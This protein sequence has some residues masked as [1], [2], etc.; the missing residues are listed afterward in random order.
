[1]RLSDGRRGMSE[2]AFLNWIKDYVAARAESSVTLRTR[3]GSESEQKL[4]CV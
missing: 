4:P 3:D 2:A 1:M